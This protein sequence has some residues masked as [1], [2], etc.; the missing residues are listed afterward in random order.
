MFWVKHRSLIYRSLSVVALV[1]VTSLYLNGTRILMPENNGYL[2]DYRYS[3]VNT[4]RLGLFG[5]RDR[6]NSMDGYQHLMN[7]YDTQRNYGL[8]DRYTESCYQRSFSRLANDALT[9]FI[10][11]HADNLKASMKLGFDRAIDLDGLRASRSPLLLLGVVAAAYTG[12]TLRYRLSS[13]FAFES[14]TT[15]LDSRF[16]RQYFGCVSSAIGAS[17]GG[18]YDADGRAMSFTAHKSIT[19]NVRMDYEKSSQ[20]SVGV[21]YSAGF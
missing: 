6:W 2:N 13:E 8:L 12:R 20:H 9:D 1:G 21:S 17:A 16:N 11:F 18:N 3:G 14:K 10:K 4:L 7:E 15:M 19:S 5:G